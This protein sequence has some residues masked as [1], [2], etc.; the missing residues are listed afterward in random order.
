MHKNGTNVIF[1]KN[2]FDMAVTS[3]VKDRVDALESDIIFSYRDLNLP[4]DRSEAVK[5]ALYRMVRERIIEKYSFKI[6]SETL[7][8]GICFLMNIAAMV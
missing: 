6:K 4:A 3:E 8:G 2:Q 7:C 5:K 1:A